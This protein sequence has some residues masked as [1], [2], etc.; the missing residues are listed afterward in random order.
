MQTVRKYCYKN[1]GKLLSEWLSDKLLIKC[2]RNHIFEKNLN[3]YYK[4][5]CSECW[6]LFFRDIEENMLN[7]NIDFNEKFNTILIQAENKT[8]FYFQNASY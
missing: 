8:T 3:N 5:W 6:E 2:K 7:Y 1:E 4:D